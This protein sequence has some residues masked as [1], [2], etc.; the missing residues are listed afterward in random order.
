[1]V[2]LPAGARLNDGEGGLQSIFFGDSAKIVINEAASKALG[3]KNPKD[4]VGQLVNMPGMSASLTICGVTADFHLGSMQ[5]HIQPV[6]FTNVNYTLYYRYLSFKIKPG[7]MQKSIAAL[8]KQWN[9]LMPGA[10]FEYHFMDE[11]I[12]N[13]YKT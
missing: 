7:D 3:W 8:Q 5:Q 2:R 11:A 9:I 13:L 10:P 4:A 1:M 12:A 6:S